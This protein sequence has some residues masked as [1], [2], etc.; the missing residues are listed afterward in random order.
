MNGNPSPRTEHLKK[1]IKNDI[2]KLGST[3][4]ISRP[5]TREARDFRGDGFA[6]AMTISA[7]NLP[8][9]SA[10]K[11]HVRK[12]VGSFHSMMLDHSFNLWQ[13]QRIYKVPA[14]YG[15][16]NVLAVPL[17]HAQEE[18][19]RFRFG[20]GKISAPKRSIAPTAHDGT[21]PSWR[22][23]RIFSR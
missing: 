6:A 20:M 8:L 10:L 22:I 14:S 11:S 4:D 3:G 7:K 18:P 5:S 12:I 16:Q 21:P 23:T 15:P 19:A 17:Q 13:T 9:R 1:P 2:I